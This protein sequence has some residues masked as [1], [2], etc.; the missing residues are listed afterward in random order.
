MTV[1]LDTIIAIVSLTL[2]IGFFAF[3]IF[4]VLKD[5]K[6]FDEVNK[7]V[8]KLEEELASYREFLEVQRKSIQ[9]APSEIAASMT[10]FPVPPD[11]KG[12]LTI[13]NL[14]EEK[15]ET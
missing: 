13:V 12:G 6:R 14:P 10:M 1:T 9:R 4:Q 8:G 7:R 11:I 15:A 3:G 2:V 5:D